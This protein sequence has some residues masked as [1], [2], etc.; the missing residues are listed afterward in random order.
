VY[1]QQYILELYDYIFQAVLSANVLGA[2]SNATKSECSKAAGSSSEKKSVS[3]PHIPPF[4]Y[5]DRKHRRRMRIDFVSPILVLPVHPL[6]PAHVE[7]DLGCWKLENEYCWVDPRSGIPLPGDGVGN[8]WKPVVG[9]SATSDDSESYSFEEAMDLQHIKFSIENMAIASVD[10]LVPPIVFPPECA[11][12]V[13]S[14]P[15]KTGRMSPTCETPS[16]KNSSDY[17][18]DG[19]DEFVDALDA[20]EAIQSLAHAV[21]EDT[22]TTFEGKDNSDT[23]STPRSGIEDSSKQRRIRLLAK[24]RVGIFVVV[25]WPVDGRQRK[26]H[27]YICNLQV[28]LFYLLLVALFRL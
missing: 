21:D 11:D 19:G 28:G 22:E 17:H 25:S 7:A 27:H 5:G 16:R 14:Q 15:S 12:D 24:E 20:F 6:T 18:G 1:V 8:G 2:G 26:P 3:L 13:S 9:D 23:Q 10:A 4:A